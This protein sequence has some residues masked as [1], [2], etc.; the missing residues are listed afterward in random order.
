M[1]AFGDD[2]LYLEKWLE[3][4]RH[5]EVQVI[6]DRYGN[7][8]HVGER[9]CSV[10]R[11]H[12]KIVEEA[13]LAGH[14][15]RAR[16]ARC[17][18]SAVEAVVA[19]GY[20]NLGTL[21][22]LLDRDGQLLLHRDQLPHPG[23]AP[24]HGDA[25]GHRPRGGADPHR[26]RRAAGLRARQTIELRGH[27]IEF[28]INAEDAAHDFRPQAGVVETLPAA[29]RPGRAHGLA[30]VQRLRGP[31][32]LR[33]AARQARRLGRR[34]ATTAIARSRVA[35]DELVV[36]GLV[37]NLAASIGRCSTTTRSWMGSSRPT[38]STAWAVPRSW[39][40]PLPPDLTETD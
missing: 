11:R 33:F 12:Q 35:L 28:R 22:F 4:N 20:E 34:T 38:C 3:D 5:V 25:L 10:Q 24:R 37:T 31:A 15:R 13:P 16:A 9:D 36:D 14:R 32:V 21:E 6:V 7:G 29:G 1:A 30:P 19:A 2:S 40:Q 8:V 27:A 17:A 39:P 26:R 23:R 18:S